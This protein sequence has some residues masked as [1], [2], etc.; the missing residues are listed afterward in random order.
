MNRGR[1]WAFQEALVDEPFDP[2]ESGSEV[3]EPP[4]AH[5]DSKEIGRPVGRPFTFHEALVGKPPRKDSGPAPVAHIS[6][7]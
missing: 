3:E 6:V 5:G 1:P 4:V 2:D 7:L